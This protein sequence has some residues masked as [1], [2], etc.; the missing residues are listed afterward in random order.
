MKKLITPVII[1]LL[2]V[3]LTACGKDTIEVTSPSIVTESPLPS[4][5]VIQTQEP[6]I[7]PIIQEPT[8]ETEETQS[9]E[10]SEVNDKLIDLTNLLSEYA[11]I[12]PPRQYGMDG[13][14]VYWQINNGYLTNDINQHA[15]LYNIKTDK[16]TM[17]P[18]WEGYYYQGYIYGIYQEVNKSWDSSS[19]NGASSIDKYDMD[20]N[21][22]AR[23]YVG[24]HK[25][26]DF[27]ILSDS[28]ILFMNDAYFNDNGDDFYYILSEDF[29]TTTKVPFDKTKIKN[30]NE[31]STH[32]RIKIIGMHD[33][34]IYIECYDNQYAVDLTTWEITPIEKINV[35]SDHYFTGNLETGELLGASRDISYNFLKFS[36]AYSKWFT[37]T[38]FYGY[39]DN[40]IALIMP[41]HNGVDD[42]KTKV[43]K[44]P[45]ETFP[46][47]AVVTDEYM[48]ITDVTGIGLY[49]FDITGAN[50]DGELIA[51]I[52]EIQE[53]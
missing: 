6:I 23:H 44:Y 31:N 19:R 4:P 37:G 12:Q 48:I 3:S 46:L 43:F 16:L 36:N 30:L 7:E 21:L 47:C 38:N 10:P 26:I 29:T 39:Y 45:N 13:D 40:G 25:T 8:S 50:T 34:Q 14:V 18:L 17:I 52:L 11:R 28:R 53:N 24:A 9:Q 49:K 42:Q 41:S 22:V 1:G 27:L 51:K 33:N 20:G 35:T 32:E 15:M 5:E 2:A